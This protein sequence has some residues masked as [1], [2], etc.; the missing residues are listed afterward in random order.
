MAKV[1]ADYKPPAY[2]NSEYPWDEWLDGRCWLLE[3]GTD[4]TSTIRSMGVS[5]R[6]AAAKRGLLVSVTAYVDPKKNERDDEKIVVQAKLQ[7]D[8]PDRSYCE[9]CNCILN[10][11]AASTHEC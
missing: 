4:F 8:D 3:H 1:L 5:I 6:K 9:N 11:D 7:T 10:N 2:H